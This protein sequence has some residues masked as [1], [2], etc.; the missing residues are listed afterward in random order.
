MKIS[1]SLYKYI[2]NLINSQGCSPYAA[3]FFHQLFLFLIAWY[4][5]SSLY[6]YPVLSP[7]FKKLSFL[8]YPLK[9]V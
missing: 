9:V 1:P 2:F 6:G 4:F 3:Q 5:A 8:L 7:Q